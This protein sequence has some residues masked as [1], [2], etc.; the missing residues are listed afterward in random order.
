MVGK[1]QNGGWS[2]R[3]MPVVPVRLDWIASAMPIGPDALLLAGPAA[4]WEGQLN[5]SR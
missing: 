3:E 4:V 5:G 2:W 1:N